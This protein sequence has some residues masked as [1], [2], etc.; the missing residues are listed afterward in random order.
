MQKEWED[1]GKL[2]KLD[3]SAVTLYFK[4]QLSQ[5]T[6]NSDFCLNKLLIFCF[7]IVSEV[8]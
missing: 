8:Q 2:Y 3:P 5:L 7:L 6:I 4:V 1:K